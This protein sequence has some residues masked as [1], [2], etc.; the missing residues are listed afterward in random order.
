[1]RY[2]AHFDLDPSTA[3]PYC[4]VLDA[5]TQR[6]FEQLSD[7]INRIIENTK[8]TM[9]LEKRAKSQTTSSEQKEIM[10]ELDR[11]IT[12]TMS[13]AKKVNDTLKSYKQKNEEYGKE[14]PHSTLTAWRI[15]KL[16][17][18][19]L[20]YQVQCIGYTECVHCHVDEAMMLYNYG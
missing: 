5:Q 3:K 4:I 1:M 19:A 2:A 12:G 10:S 15:N 7:L 16:N 9:N 11:L 20:R 14:N 8:S 13:T 6:E 17:T 18:S